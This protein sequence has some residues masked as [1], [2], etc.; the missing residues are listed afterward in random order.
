M[1]EEPTVKYTGA[2]LSVL[3]CPENVLVPDIVPRID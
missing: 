1:I 3:L 2:V